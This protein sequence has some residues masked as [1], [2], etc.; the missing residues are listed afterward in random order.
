MK[1]NILLSTII[2]VCV[3]SLLPA[4]EPTETI[5]V[6]N[7]SDK[8]F[9]FQYKNPY[10]YCHLLFVG[11]KEALL[12]DTGYTATAEELFSKVKILTAD[13]LLYLVNTHAHGD[14]IQGNYN[15]KNNA[16]IMSHPNTR[17]RFFAKYYSLPVRE[18]GGSPDLTFENNISL[19]ID[20]Q[21]ILIK[22]TPRGHTDGDLIF[23]FP[24]DNL[25]FAGDIIFP[26]A[27]PLA[28]TNMGGD[29]DG[30]LE[31]LKGLIEIY[32][33]NTRFLATH[34]GF[35]DKG[36]LKD[37][38]QRLLKSAEIIKHEIS[39]GQTMDQIMAGEALKEFSDWA[40]A[41]PNLKR[42]WINA[43]CT[44]Y[45]KAVIL[46]SIN[47]PMTKELVDIGIEVAIKKYHELKNS[48]PEKYNF[49]ENQL[50]ELGYE[51]LYRKMNKEA[52]EVLKLNTVVYPNSSNVFDSLA[53]AYMTDNQIELAIQNYKKSLELDPSNANAKNFIEQLQAQKKK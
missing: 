48:S 5:E 42:L 8:L 49:A 45:E 50:N 3:V 21:E 11:E 38:Y 47:D 7:L 32:P 9:L 28:A 14:H 37:Y 52:I 31:V 16:V 12:I 35:Y 19:Y 41:S 53:E 25:L 20:N 17:D 15:F 22:H 4:D 44:K 24:K 10:D 29:A 34:G 40:D 27:F 1:K 2:L 36:Q 23:Y 30:Y 6:K 39:K 51:L 33:D 26:K 46:T 18:L 43:L 13:K